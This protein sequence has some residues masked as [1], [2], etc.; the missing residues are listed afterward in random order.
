MGSG[1][2]VGDVEFFQ[3]LDVFEHAAKLAFEGGDFLVGEGEACQ[4]GDMADIEIR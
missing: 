3:M 1:L 2:D 4:P